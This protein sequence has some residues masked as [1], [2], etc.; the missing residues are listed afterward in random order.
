MTPRSGCRA[1]GV[2]SYRVDAMNNAEAK[3]ESALMTN[4]RFRPKTADTR[5]PSDAPIASMADHVAL[6]RAFAGNS[7]SGD[8]TFGIV[9]VRAGSKKACAPTVSAVTT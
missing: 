3:K 6:E 2:A 9:A 8:V 4:A 5:P 7:S 1:A